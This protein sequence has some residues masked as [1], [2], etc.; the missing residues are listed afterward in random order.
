MPL[1]LITNK[2]EHTL[3]H[4]QIGKVLAT[5]K[6]K[7]QIG[8]TFFKLNHFFKKKWDMYDILKEKCFLTCSKC[9][10]TRIVEKKLIEELKKENLSFECKFNLDILFNL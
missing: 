8:I 1:R 4:L 10:K 3:A 9:K 7:F 5:R 6:M 2:A